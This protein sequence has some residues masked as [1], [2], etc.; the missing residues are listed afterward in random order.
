M[1][2]PIPSHY[3]EENSKQKTL[4]VISFGF[5]TTKHLIK[6]CL[7]FLSIIYKSMRYK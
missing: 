5:A 1:R 7:Y 2:K 4:F 3:E 6:E